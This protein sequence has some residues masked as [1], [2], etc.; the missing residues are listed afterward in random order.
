VGVRLESGRV[1]SPPAVAERRVELL[2]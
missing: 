1:A 2:L